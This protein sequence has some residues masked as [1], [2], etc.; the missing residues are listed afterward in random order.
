MKHWRHIAR[1]TLITIGLV[2]AQRLRFG[3]MRFM[4]EGDL[5]FIVAALPI[6]IAFI[7]AEAEAKAHV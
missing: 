5:E 3:P 4:V 1:V 2:L 7:W 6:V